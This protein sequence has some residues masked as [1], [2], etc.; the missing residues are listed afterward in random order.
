MYEPMGLQITEKERFV[1]MLRRLIIENRRAYEA[2]PSV[3][4]PLAENV[5]KAVESSFGGAQTRHFFL[6]STTVFT[7]VPA[8]NPQWDH[9]E[10]VFSYMMRDADM[11]E[12][13]KLEEG[14]KKRIAN[15]YWNTR[16]PERDL[17][18]EK[19]TTLKGRLLSDWDLE[20]YSIHRFNNDDES[21][22]P[23]NTVLQTAEINHFQLF[24]ESLLPLLSA[25]EKSE[26]RA[27]AKEFL[28]ELLAPDPLTESGLEGYPPEVISVL[29]EPIPLTL[30]YPDE[31]RRAI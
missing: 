19:I 8:D 27:Y 7:D 6:W 14:K 16:K 29:M 28:S 25:A 3:I 9:W 22:D 23:F 17:L 24:W 18:E 21:F 1:A 13:L 30:P 31:L 4:P 10:I 20:M 26:L 15:V 2:N 5:L 12:K 11:W